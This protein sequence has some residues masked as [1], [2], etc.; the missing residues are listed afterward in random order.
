MS[1]VRGKRINGGREAAAAAVE[2]VHDMKE[3]FG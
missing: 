1:G 3:V 2:A